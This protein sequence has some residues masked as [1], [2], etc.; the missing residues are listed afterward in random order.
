MHLVDGEINAS[1]SA[2]RALQNLYELK[3]ENETVKGQLDAQ[4]NE[5]INRPTI[6]DDTHPSH[7]DRFKLAEKI[8]SRDVF[9]VRGQVWDVFKDREALTNEMNALIVQRIRTS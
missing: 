4:F 9:P 1:Y 8:R 3:V 5:A 7:A 2:K 6:E